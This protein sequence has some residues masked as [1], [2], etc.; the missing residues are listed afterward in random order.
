M[1]DF[2]VFVRGEN[3]LTDVDGVAQRV[4]FFTTCHVEAVSAEL[5]GERAVGLLRAD[6]KLIG[7]ARNPDDDPFRLVIEEVRPI[8]T[9]A[10]L[11]LPR[12]GLAVFP[13]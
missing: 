3:F 1:G 8:E 6:P 4:G 9:F 2:S 10:G 13:E 7:L 11:R 5:A 12:T